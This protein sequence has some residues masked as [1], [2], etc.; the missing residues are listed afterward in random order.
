MTDQAAREAAKPIDGNAIG[1]EEPRDK[2]DYHSKQLKKCLG[3]ESYNVDSTQLN[4]THQTSVSRLILWLVGFAC[5]RRA[6]MIL[7][8]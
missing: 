1:A 4:V 5:T 8:Y 6:A 3:R 2:V 7:M